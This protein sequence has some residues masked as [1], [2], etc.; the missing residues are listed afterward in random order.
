MV[1]LDKWLIGNDE[2]ESGSGNEN[3]AE[4]LLD[5]GF[6]FQMEVLDEETVFVCNMC[7]EM[8]ETSEIVEKLILKEHK[9]ELKDFEKEFEDVG[10]FE[11]NTDV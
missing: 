9:G 2:I 7:H 3:K 5:Y 1:R 11:D 6:H 8:F 4:E 10:E